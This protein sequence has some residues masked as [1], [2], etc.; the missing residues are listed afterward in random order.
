MRNYGGIKLINQIATNRYVD[1]A[2]ITNALQLL[3]YKEDFY[4]VFQKFGMIY[5]FSDMDNYYSLKKSVNETFAGTTYNLTPI[6]L[7]NYPF[8]IYE[9]KQEAD[10]D[11]YNTLFNKYN[12]LFEY[13]EQYWIKG[14]WIYKPTYTFTEDIQ[15]YG[16][17]VY[18]LGNIEAGKKYEIKHNSSLSLTVV[19]RE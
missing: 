3:G 10:N 8:K 11:F 18:Y 13:Y 17:C 1:E 9:S 12:V 19:V 6:R 16:F 14:P 7:Y 2:S 15:P 5:I 4:T